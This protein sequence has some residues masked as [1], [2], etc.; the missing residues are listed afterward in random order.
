MEYLHWLWYGIYVLIVLIVMLKVL[1]DN[2][3]PAKTMAWLLVLWAL[4]LVGIVLYFFFGQ[5]TRKER[6]ISQRS[7]DQLTKRSMLE[8]VEQR[9]L[10]LPDAHRPLMQLFKNQSMALPFK[11]NLVDIYTSGYQFFPAL[12]QAISRARHHIHIDIY[13]FDD[14]ALGRLIADTLID[15]SR[16]GVEIR[17][18]YDDVACWKV[19]NAFFE[20]MRNA[21]I[22]IHPFMPV[23]FPAFTS[24]ANYRNHRKLIIIDGREA[25]IG[26]M[27]FATRYV[28]GTGR[29]PWRDTMLH[30]TGGAVYGIQ[31]AFLIDW[32][33]VDRTLLSDRL[34]YPPVNPA[35][36][37]NCLAQVVTSG[38][39]TE[40]PDIMQGYVRILLEA[41]RYVYMETPYF[42]PTEPVLFAMR[43]AALA[44]VDVRLM[45]PRHSD[46]H[47]V[48][49][50][51]F[52]YL[53]EIIEAGVKVYLY[54]SGFN[55]SKFLVSD[56]SISTCGSTNI[57]F[58]SFEHNFESSI[59]FYDEGMALR[60]KKVF[61]N[62]QTQCRTF[63]EVYQ[64]YHYTFLRRLWTSLVRLLSPL[65]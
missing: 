51:S 9:N 41:R 60:M 44:G 61:L 19:K 37:N 47:I 40:W 29:Q 64:G 57:D 43:T 22:D 65:L 36:N 8:F 30:V 54:E 14:D 23:K 15:K 53:L 4:P 25:F 31:R 2:R 5:N 7:L 6:L 35:I 55:H 63:N 48:E 46:S 3:Q 1:M 20:R 17:I 27:N 39:I 49:W 10:R 34:Y 12:L 50:A 28:K 18:I 56:D 38:P 42:L 62:D 58:R 33:F 13:I 45:I 16:Q 59:F 26:G 24:K 52:S 11:D 32:Y 21:G